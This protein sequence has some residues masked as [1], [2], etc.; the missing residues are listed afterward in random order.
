[1]TVTEFATLHALDAII[2]PEVKTTLINAQSVQDKWVAKAFPSSPLSS[3]KQ[4]SAW[5]QQIEDPK[6]VL[7]IAQWDSVEAHWQWIRDDVNKNLMTELSGRVFDSAKGF[8]LFHVG[9][10]IFGDDGTITPGVVPLLESPVLSVSRIYVAPENKQSFA[11]KFA[12]VK[13]SL[14]EHIRP[15]VARYG[16][17]EDREEAAEQE[18]FLLV[19]GW[20]SAEKHFEFAQAPEFAQFSQIQQYV[21]R[22][23][24]KHYKRII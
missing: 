23:D 13:G 15:R 17:R 3:S 11:A 14:E 5:L 16:W 18:E 2:T 24:I 12:E 21:S 20:E 19:T 10:D 7:T 9:C 8:D 6:Q 22:A 4:T 1:M